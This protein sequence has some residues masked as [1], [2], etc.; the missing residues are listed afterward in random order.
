M[1]NNL[2]FRLKGQGQAALAVVSM[3]PE[4]IFADPNSTF[5]DGAMGG[6]QYLQEIVKRCQVYY[7][8]ED[9]LPRIYGAESTIIHLNWVNRN[10]ILRGANLSKDPSTFSTMNFT[11]SIGNP[12]YSDRSG[13]SSKSPDLDSKF[14]EK[15][16][17]MA[18]RVTMIIRSKHFT[19]PSSKFRKKLFAGGHLR[20]IKVLPDNTFAIQNTETCIIDWD[21]SY[22]GP[23]RVTYNDGTIVERNLTIDTVI[24]LNNPNYVAEVDNNLAH[25]WVRGKLNRNKMIDGPSPVVEV[26]GSGET[27]VIKNCQSGQEDIARNTHGVVINVAADWGSLGHIMVKPYNAAISSSV[28]CLI[29]QTEEEAIY[30]REYLTSDNIKEIVKLNMPSFH[31]TKE[32]FKKIADPLI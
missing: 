4:S 1:K 25:R 16:M 32:L 26:C 22:S 15:S 14:I 28:M 2:L 7:N 30:L 3:L 12:P 20:S 10:T 8:I 5:Y 18:D 6:G 23:C 13:D 29:T 21:A 11:V 19:S 27:P 31:P 24:K 9:I 17:G